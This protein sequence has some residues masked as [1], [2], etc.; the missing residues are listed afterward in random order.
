MAQRSP[1][2]SNGWSVSGRSGRRL[3]ERSA[4]ACPPD[5]REP[6]ATAEAFW[7]RC[8]CRTC[9]ALSAANWFRVGRLLLTAIHGTNQSLTVPSPDQREFNQFDLSRYLAGA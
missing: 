8:V 6:S 5:F 7:V 1:A 3:A 9:M 4:P 2:Q